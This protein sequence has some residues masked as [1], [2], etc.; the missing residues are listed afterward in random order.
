MP[1]FSRSKIICG[2]VGMIV[3]FTTIL[4]AEVSPL[5]PILGIALFLII[6]LIGKVVK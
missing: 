1:H 2:V 4:F 6:V 3:L 5:I